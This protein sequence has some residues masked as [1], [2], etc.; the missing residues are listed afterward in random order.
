MKTKIG[1]FV[2]LLVTVILFWQIDRAM[3]DLLNISEI[4]WT[5]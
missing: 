4:D 1:F 3:R 2:V 5:Y